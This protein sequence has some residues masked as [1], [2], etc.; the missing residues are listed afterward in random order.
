MYRAGTSVDTSAADAGFWDPKVRVPVYSFFAAAARS[1]LLR[2]AK[3]TEWGLAG[4]APTQMTG[5][6][7]LLSRKKNWRR[8]NPERCAACYRNPGYGGDSTPTGLPTSYFSVLDA[9]L[10]SWGSQSAGFPRRWCERPRGALDTVRGGRATVVHETEQNIAKAL[11]CIIS[12]TYTPAPDFCGALSISPEQGGL[13]LLRKIAEEYPT[14][15]P[16]SWTFDLD[17][18]HQHSG[19]PVLRVLGEGLVPRPHT[20]RGLCRN[21]R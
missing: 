17:G 21:G 8:W 6:H 2:F 7:H 14:A 1:Y 5:G 10:A 19:C 3:E 16:T 13:S 18:H 11:R 20:P 15:W 4:L 9:D 12:S